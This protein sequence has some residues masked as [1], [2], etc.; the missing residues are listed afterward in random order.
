MRNKALFFSCPHLELRT[1][2]ALRAPRSP[3]L[4]HTAP[5]IQARADQ[6]LYAVICRSLGGL[7]ANEREENLHPMVTLI[8]LF[9]SSTVPPDSLLCRHQ[10]LFGYVV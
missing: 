6:H 7:S 1:P 9:Y 2:F 4:A 8:A 3:R 5:D 10:K